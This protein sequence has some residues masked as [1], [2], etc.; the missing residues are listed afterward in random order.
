MQEKL[1]GSE[2]SSSLQGE[3]LAVVSNVANPVVQ[4]TNYTLMV[5]LYLKVPIYIPQAKVLR[6]SKGKETK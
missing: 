2:L 1:I 6:F 4:D 5:L 3:N